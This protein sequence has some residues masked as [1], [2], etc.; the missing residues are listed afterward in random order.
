MYQSQIAPHNITLMFVLY[1]NLNLLYDAADAQ[2][3]NGEKPEEVP[4]NPWEGS[5]PH[6]SV[7][8]W[9]FPP[10]LWTTQWIPPLC[11]RVQTEPG[12]H[13]DHETG[14]RTCRFVLLFNLGLS[15]LYL[16]HSHQRYKDI[17]F[18][19]EMWQTRQLQFKKNTEQSY[20]QN[21]PVH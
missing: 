6:W 8:M 15:N 5:W 12:Q 10:N 16:I 7:Q 1:H 17:Y 14:E 9:L 4:Q 2:E 19:R 3:P 21:I 18:P 20:N 11:G 13:L